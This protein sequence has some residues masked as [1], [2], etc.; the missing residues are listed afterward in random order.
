MQNDQN[1]L[2]D[3]YLWIAYSSKF[4]SYMNE[5]AINCPEIIKQFCEKEGIRDC[6]DFEVINQGSI[7]MMLYGIFVVPKELWENTS[8]DGNSGIWEKFNFDSRNTFIELESTNSLSKEIFLR[9]FRN[10]LAH[11]NFSVDKER[12][13]IQF[14]NCNSDNHK[15]F[16][17]E[18]TPRG[19]GEFA[20]EVSQHFFH[21]S[22]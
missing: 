3:L 5:Y 22:D 14:W 12:G 11:S 18:N 20:D 10:S 6:K 19:L 15:N 8:K 4:I 16:M 2:K 7:I 9:R 13:V 1:D 17:V 21:I